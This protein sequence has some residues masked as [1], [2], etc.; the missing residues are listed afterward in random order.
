MMPAMTTRTA[1]GAAL[2]ALTFAAAA[3]PAQETA[4][5]PDSPPAAETLPEAEP[6]VTRTDALVNQALDAP[7]ELDLGRRDLPD[8]L[9]AITE[10]TGVP[11]GVEESTYALL[12]YGRQTP[13]GVSVTATP[14]RQTL[15]AITQRLGLRYVLRDERV[16]L[17]PLPALRRAGRRATVEEVAMLDLLAGVRLDLPDDRP[18]T[19]DL[20]EAVDLKLQELDRAASEAGRPE[21]G[22]VVENRLNDA[23]RESRVAVPRN[24][25]L[26]EAMEA[27]DNQNQGTW[28]PWGD[29]LVA[30]PKDAHVRQLLGRPVTLEYDRAA[31]G[32]V[33][34]DLS[35]ATGV[36]FRVEPGALAAVPEPYQRVQ[37]SLANVSAAEA[38]EIIGGA[39][40]LAYAVEGDGV[41]IYHADARRGGD[42]PIRGNGVNGR[43]AGD[44]PVMSVDLGDGTSLL[45]YESD[46][47]PAALEKLDARRRAAIDA[48]TAG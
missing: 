43:G 15:A 13:I 1:R 11:F 46:L 24:A 45:I 34:A 18:T 23:Q 5:A 14:L 21:P 44:A 6:S 27:I 38:L 35:T 33:I 2:L 42:G 22:Y 19:A 10:R 12:P 26:L 20:L 32:E 25:T 48:L 36:P 7:V 17:E 3:A 30:L 9:D 47:P 31:V 37:L 39:T 28:Y 41:T 40:G 29:T 4:P 8:V 16:D